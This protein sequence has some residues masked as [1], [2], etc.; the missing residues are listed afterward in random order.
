MFAIGRYYSSTRKMTFGGQ[1][2]SVFTE[3][4]SLLPITG[5]TLGIILNYL[6][7]N[8]LIPR[9]PVSV[10]PVNKLLIQGE[11]AV[12]AFAIGCSLMLRNIRKYWRECATVCGLKF[13]VMPIVGLGVVFLMRSLALLSPEPVV[14]KTIFIETCMPSAIMSVVFAKLFLLDEHMSNSIWV[15]TTIATVA[16]LP[17]V[18]F[19]VT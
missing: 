14:Q 2:K 11:V 19:I 18:Y 12:C 7:R 15:V 17:V 10:L 6:A 4:L 1:L 5:F 9:P 8:E 3:P 13:V 16:V